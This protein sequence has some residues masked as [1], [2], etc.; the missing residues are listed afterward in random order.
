MTTI[1]EKQRAFLYREMMPESNQDVH[2]LKMN[3]NAYSVI[4]GQIQ[5]RYCHDV[6]CSLK[7]TFDFKQLHAS[8][9]TD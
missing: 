1:G 8:L 9:I 3:K 4:L 6:Y 5:G 7:Q 2:L